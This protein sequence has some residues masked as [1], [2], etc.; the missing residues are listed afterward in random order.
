MVSR[1]KLIIYNME[2][3]I[4][5]FLPIKA[6]K[7]DKVSIKTSV[8]VN[9]KYQASHTVNHT[10]KNELPNTGGVVGIRKK[11]DLY[12]VMR[13]MP[14]FCWSEV[15]LN[16]LSATEKNNHYLTDSLQKEL[17]YENLYL[18]YLRYA[19]ECEQQ[20]DGN[21]NKCDKVYTFNFNN[22]YKTGIEEIPLGDCKCPSLYT[23]PCFRKKED[24][25]NFIRTYKERFHVLK[26]ED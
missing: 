14:E 25:I 15:Y 8:F 18:N 26:Q 20:Y 13:P 1:I 23:Y 17:D 10:V 6:K 24:L 7:G 2:Q 5:E 22:S 9:G 21:I 12:K 11:F 19:W 3:K 4:E 16:G